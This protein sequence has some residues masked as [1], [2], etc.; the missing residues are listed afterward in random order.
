MKSLDQ[1]LELLER[2][3]LILQATGFDSNPPEVE[4]DGK[5]VA[6]GQPTDCGEL[7]NLETGQRIKGLFGMGL[8]FDILPAG[9]GY[10]EPGFHG[11]LHGFQSY[12]LTIAPRLIDKIMLNPRLEE[13]S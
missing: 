9:A 13:V 6:I 4:I 5:S 3:G 8:G 1:Q 7:H 10:G 11:G 2:A 12:P